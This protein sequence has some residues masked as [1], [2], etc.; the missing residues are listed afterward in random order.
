MSVFYI[1]CAANEPKKLEISLK[2]ETLRFQELHKSLLP[3]FYFDVNKKYFYFLD[4]EINFKFLKE[5]N[6]NSTIDDVFIYK[7]QEECNE[8]FKAIFDWFSTE[9]TLGNS[10][11][12]IR[13][14][15]TENKDE[16]LQYNT[17]YENRSLS[18]SKCLDSSSN[19][20]FEFNVEYEIVA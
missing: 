3:D 20:E 4:G 9:I 17:V 12:L 5:P 15:E 19:F 7:F 10:V 16:F 14:I 11:S 13:Q 2:N 6:Q 8:R 18:L 1:I